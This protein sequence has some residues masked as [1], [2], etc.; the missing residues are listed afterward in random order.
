MILFDFSG[1]C[2][3]LSILCLNFGILFKNSSLLWVRE[4]L[5]GCGMVLFLIK[6]V[7]EFEWCG[8]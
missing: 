8:V 2:S 4:I 6:V 3:E 7:I 1:L 5:L